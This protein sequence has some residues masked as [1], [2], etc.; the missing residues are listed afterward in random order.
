MS[1][2]QNKATMRRIYDVMNDRNMERAGEFIATDLVDH[3]AFPGQ[4]PG[5]EGFKQSLTM[6]RSAFPD[7][8]FTV[9]DMLAEGDQVATRFT[10]HGTHH[11]DFMDI[12]P[13]GKQIQVSAFDLCR[14]ADGKVV[15]HWGQVDMMGMME[16]LG[17]AGAP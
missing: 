16:Q 6:F 17:V 5:L 14:F 10:V 7:L 13:T 12:P 15:E 4:A 8:H 2:E 11:S 1:T 9:E 3:D